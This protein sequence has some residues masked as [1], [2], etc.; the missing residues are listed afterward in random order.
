MTNASN[1]TLRFYCW[2]AGHLSRLSPTTLCQLWLAG[3]LLWPWVDDVLWQKT[4]HSHFD[5]WV[6]VQCAAA[7][8][9]VI[10]EGYRTPWPWV[11]LDELSHNSENISSPNVQRMVGHWAH[12][13][14][15]IPTIW[16]SHVNAGVYWSYFGMCVSLIF[17]CRPEMPP[18]H[19][20][21]RWDQSFAC[22]EV[23]KSSEQKQ[24][25]IQRWK[26]YLWIPKPWDNL[27]VIVWL[28]GLLSRSHG[29]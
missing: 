17:K 7:P 22:A 14:G 18:F 26:C 13:R 6:Q 10:H 29:V 15:C 25:G 2:A 8:A 23:Q 21:I 12:E 19:E 1:F 3:E 27:P 5:V 9:E 20:P 11:R 28:S 24:V 16:L 4:Q